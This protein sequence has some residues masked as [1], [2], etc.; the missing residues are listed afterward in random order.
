MSEK[1]VHLNTVDPTLRYLQATILLGLGREDEAV[2]ALRRVLFLDGDFILA[3][4]TLGN[5]CRQNGQNQQ[6]QRHFRNTLD[7]VAPLMRDQVLED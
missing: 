6:A 3:H 2:Q 7:L 1:A 5:L 4:F